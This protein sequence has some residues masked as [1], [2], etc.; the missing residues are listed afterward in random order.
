[1][2]YGFEDEENYEDDTALKA[3]EDLSEHL[4]KLTNAYQCTMSSL[5]NII[6]KMNELDFQFSSED[7]YKNFISEVKRSLETLITIQTEVQLTN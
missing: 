3:L 4:R 1:M 5:E 7:D 2:F 6:A